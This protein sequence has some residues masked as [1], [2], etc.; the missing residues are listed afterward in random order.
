MEL[1]ELVIEVIGVSASGVLAPG[2]LFFANLLYG[3]RRGAKAGLKMA[4]GH[5]VVELPLVVVLAAGIFSFAAILDAHFE[6]IGIVGGIAILAF[7][8]IHTLSLKKTRA[9][10]DS[11]G[12][13]NRRPFV[14]GVLLSALNPFFLIWWVTV[15][16]KIL[17]DSSSFGIVASVA[18]VFGFHIW[19]DYAWLTGT[20]YLASKGGAMLKSRYYVILNL[21]LIGV[22]V[23]FG[24]NFLIAP[25]Q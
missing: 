7:A 8:G 9:S 14:A 23:Y 3:A 21:A 4:Y 25:L 12:L 16:L 17:T 20:A 5:T 15:G 11:I 13:S 24:L 10:Q 6:T 1:P 2:P 19:M 22:L 18:I